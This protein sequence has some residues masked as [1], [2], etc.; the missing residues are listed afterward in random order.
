MEAKQ[1]QP[2]TE[3]E[4]GQII[5]EAKQAGKD[6]SGLEKTL[7]TRGEIKSPPLGEKI[8]IKPTR[9]DKGVVT[10]ESTGPARE[11]DFL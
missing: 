5:K 4:L 9:G 11:D 1:M 10:I 3:E 8:E 2:V 7:G 6:V